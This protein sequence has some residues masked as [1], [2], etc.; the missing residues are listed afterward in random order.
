MQPAAV[1]CKL[2]KWNKTE[3]KGLRSSTWLTMSFHHEISQRT[4]PNVPSVAFPPLLLPINTKVCV[5]ADDVM[6]YTGSSPSP[7]T[8]LCTRRLR[9]R[10]SWDVRECAPYKLHFSP[11]RSRSCTLLVK[12]LPNRCAFFARP[13]ESRH[14]ARHFTR[15]STHPLSDAFFPNV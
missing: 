5:A 12:L 9:G 7:D 1:R 10:G 3:N 6:I 15:V 2:E 14:S 8:S 11:L 4:G 13:F